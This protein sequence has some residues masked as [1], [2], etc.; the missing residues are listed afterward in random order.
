MI[1][2][3]VLF[4]AR[5][6][7]GNINSRPDTYSIWDA[8]KYGL[9]SHLDNLITLDYYD[10]YFENGKKEF[11]KILS[12]LIQKEKIKYLFIG[13]AADD[14]VIDLKFL[15]HLKNT[16]TLCIINTSQDPETFFESRDR[17]Y[18]QIADYILPFTILPNGS[19]YKNYNLDT[20]TLYSI[21]NKDMF[22][23]KKSDKTIDVSFIGNLNKASRKD[24]VNYL[25]ENNINIQTYGV[26][27]DN[28][29]VNHKQMIE[30]I[31]TSKI[32][33]NFTDSASSLYFDYNTNTNFT[34]GTKINSKIQQAKGR[35]IEIFLTNSFCLSQEG[36]GTRVLFD[37]DRIIF[38]NKEE[39][40]KQ[41]QYYLN[42]SK[43]RDDI[44]QELYSHSL[45]FDAI[46]R[47]ND[48]LP[49]L[50]YKS[51]KIDKLYI[52]KDFIRNYTSYHFLFFFNFLYKGKINFLS[53]E[54]K[55]FFRYKSFN[56]STIYSHFKMQSIYAYKRM[57]RI[58]K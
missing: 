54:I 34:I 3:K 38:K 20:I 50:K 35:L 45:K 22:E 51:T 15:V 18:N 11:E 16:Y 30:V 49:Q 27:S 42:N 26:G 9:N 46:N 8:Y 24:L 36:Q 33:L 53:E 23:N 13:F 2:E 1:N 5:F 55:I 6:S 7:N 37:D 4:L 31:N 44:T 32:N 56:F 25:K 17:Y 43:E 28:G 40:L 47:L 21:Y 19:L 39:L 29:F 10:L 14:F 48:I 58:K 52:D 57:K 41:I 12:N